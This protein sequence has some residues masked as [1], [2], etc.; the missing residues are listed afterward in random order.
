MQ[1]I[2]PVVVV[3]FLPYFIFYSNMKE[4]RIGVVK[5]FTVQ[6]KVEN[7]AEDSAYTS[8]IKLR[9]P[10]NLDYIGPDQVIRTT[11]EGIV[12]TVG[13]EQFS[14]ECRK[15]KTKVITLTN[16]NRRRTRSKYMQR[17]PS[18]GG[19][20]RQVAICFGFISEQLIKWRESFLDNHKT[21]QCK[22]KADAKISLYTRL[23]TALSLQNSE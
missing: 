13:K 22:T 10:D 2:C 6:L 11:E 16:D 9:H 21:E 17:T 18:A 7:K 1:C 5:D 20:V 19:R 4:L 3:V 15:T 23:K 8:K 12:R 14:V